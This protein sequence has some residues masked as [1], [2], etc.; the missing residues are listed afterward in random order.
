MLGGRIGRAADLRQQAGRRNRVEEIAAAARLHARDQVPRRIDMGHDMNGPA[1]LPRLVGA[2][3]G[4][5][6]HRIEAA[7][8]AGIGAEQ[9]N[10]AELMLGLLDDVKDI[11]LLSD[12]AFE[13]R[14]AD[15]RGDGRAPSGSISATTTLARRRDGRPRT[16]PCRCRCR[17][18]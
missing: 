4:I 16:S 13:G 3:A 2:S 10:R 11:L 14:P 1:A 9:R 7:A 15:R 12:I 5:H 18:R 8:D 17:R 6:R